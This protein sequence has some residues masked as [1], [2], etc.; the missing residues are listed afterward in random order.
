MAVTS[1][2][3]EYIKASM[4]TYEV[5]LLWKLLVALLGQRVETIMIHCD[6][7]SYIRVSENLVFHGSSKHIDIKYHFIRD[8][9][10]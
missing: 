10:Q 9:V 7:Q 2:E 3:A 4:A 6:N 8:C 1:R 5:I